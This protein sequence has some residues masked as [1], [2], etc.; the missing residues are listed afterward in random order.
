MK[1]SYYFNRIPMEIH[2]KPSWNSNEIPVEISMK[3][4]L[5]PSKI[6]LIISMKYLWKSIWSP[7]EKF[8]LKYKWNSIENLGRISMKFLYRCQLNTNL[9]HTG[10]MDFI[11]SLMMNINE[12]DDLNA[13]TVVTQNTILPG[14]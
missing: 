9:N 2:L 1:Y 4:Q 5:N 6:R 3:Y 7:F 8:H 10:T 14:S 12:I 11:G 13:D